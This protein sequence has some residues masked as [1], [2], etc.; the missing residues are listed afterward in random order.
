MALPAG[1]KFIEYG[2]TDKPYVPCFL[3]AVEATK[4]GLCHYESFTFFSEEEFELA[5]DDAVKRLQKRIQS[6]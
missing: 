2:G 1:M 6:F 3:S 4:D 5:A